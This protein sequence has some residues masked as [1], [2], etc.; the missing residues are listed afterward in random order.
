MK[1]TYQGM[2]PINWRIRDKTFIHLV[3]QGMD[4]QDAYDI[5]M[6]RLHRAEGINLPWSNPPASLL[7]MLGRYGIKIYMPK[8]E[9]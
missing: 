4:T 6:C 8:E 5:A 9:E 3:L 1:N 7:G 2:K